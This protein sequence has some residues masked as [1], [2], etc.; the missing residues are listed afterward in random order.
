MLLLSLLLLLLLLLPQLHRLL[1]AQLA[2]LL[3]EPEQSGLEDLVLRTVTHEEHEE[4][5][6]S[7]EK[8]QARFSSILRVFPHLP[9]LV[10]GPV[11]RGKYMYID[12]FFFAIC[13]SYAGTFCHTT[14]FDT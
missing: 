6:L 13:V 9:I 2:L 1:R 14:L 10:E 3:F 7:G 11:S 12:V 5:Q 8:M 4:Q